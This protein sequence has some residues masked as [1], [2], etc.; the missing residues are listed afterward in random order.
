MDGRRHTHSHK[1]LNVRHASSHILRARKF[2]L[3]L[4]LFVTFH[5]SLCLHF[6]HVK[7]NLKLSSLICGKSE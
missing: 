6:T 5:H 4:G 1:Q 2:L 7:I 3:F